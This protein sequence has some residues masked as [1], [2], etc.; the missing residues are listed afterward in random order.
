MTGLIRTL[1]LFAWVYLFL[2]W[3][4]S[5]PWIC[6]SFLVHFSSPCKLC[7]P[8]QGISWKAVFTH[9]IHSTLL[10]SEGELMISQGSAVGLPIPSADKASPNFPKR[11]WTSPFEG[12]LGQKPL[13]WRVFLRF[14]TSGRSGGRQKK[15]KPREPRKPEQLQR[16]L[17][18]KE[19]VAWHTQ[20]AHQRQS[21]KAERHWGWKKR[22]AGYLKER[23]RADE[24]RDDGSRG[25]VEVESAGWRGGNKAETA[26]GGKRIIFPLAAPG[27]GIINSSTYC[28]HAPVS[29]KRNRTLGVF[30]FQTHRN[31]REN[32]FNH[33][34]STWRLL[35]RAQIPLGWAPSAESPWNS[36]TNCFPASQAAVRRR[37]S[38]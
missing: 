5:S 28:P 23:V 6:V 20:R 37:Q 17:L 10:S 11:N 22:E 1:P 13:C 15:W 3:I 16:L 14:A 33:L 24:V 19:T 27:L 34:H 2:F 7:D 9:F 35:R 26:Q 29:D 38:L 4:F 12:T 36:D 25:N 8:L 18:N 21:W 32:S 30:L 31:R